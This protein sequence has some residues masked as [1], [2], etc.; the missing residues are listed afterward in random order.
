[1]EKDLM[2]FRQNLEIPAIV[3]K[4]K[5]RSLERITAIQEQSL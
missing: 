4:A 2:I 1:M 5:L 3:A